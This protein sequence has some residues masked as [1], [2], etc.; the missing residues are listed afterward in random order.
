MNTL[1]EINCSCIGEMG[2]FGNQ[3]FQFAYAQAHA[4]KNNYRLCTPYWDGQKVFDIEAQP[5]EKYFVRTK[6]DLHLPDADM[7][8][9]HS[10]DL[11]GYF[12]Q[13]HHIDTWFENRHKL[14]RFRKNILDNFNSIP[15]LYVAIHLRRGDYR[16]LPNFPVIDYAY[17]EKAVRQFNIN[18]PIVIITDENPHHNSYYNSL[19]LPWLQDFMLLNRAEYI[20]TANS[21]FSWWAAALS[22]AFLNRRVFSPVRTKDGQIDFTNGLAMSNIQCR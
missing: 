19:G 4:S 20:L 21:S 6:K 16:Y 8:D 10:I 22:N 11:I 18:L 3:M 15:H 1:P 7:G 17:Y 5:I 13:A 2:R 9:A 12:Q 14:F